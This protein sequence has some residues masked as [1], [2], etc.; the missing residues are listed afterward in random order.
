GLEVE[1]AELEA[2]AARVAELE[3]RAAEDLAEVR[4]LLA[5]ISLQI[6]QAEEHKDG[7]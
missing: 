6:A 2:D 1:R 4:G 7:L 3:A 5:T